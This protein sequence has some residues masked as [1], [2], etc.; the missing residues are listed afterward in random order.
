MVLEQVESDVA[1]L[2]A[3]LAAFEAKHAELTKLVSDLE[4]FVKKVEAMMAAKGT[5]SEAK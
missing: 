2:K 1:S 3:R 5:T 4:S